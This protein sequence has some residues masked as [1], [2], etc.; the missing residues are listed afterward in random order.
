MH[1]DEC[2]QSKGEENRKFHLENE[3]NAPIANIDVEDW[4][5]DLISSEPP[6]PVYS[7]SKEAS[8]KLV[9]SEFSEPWMDA[10]FEENN[11]LK[12]RRNR[13]LSSTDGSSPNRGDDLIETLDLCNSLEDLV[14]T[15]DKNVKDCL[16]NYNNIDIGQLAP[17]QV[18]TE[19]DLVNDSQ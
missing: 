16:K 10:D 14:K 15:F 6:A 3:L 9:K 4:L 17:V 18:R 8:S 19:E 5:I 2:V 1:L 12:S 11:T 13:R 7:S